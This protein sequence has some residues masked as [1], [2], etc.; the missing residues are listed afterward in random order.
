MRCRAGA[1]G[2]PAVNNANRSSSRA[3]ICSADN[4]RARAAAS[5]IANGIPSTRRHTRATATRLAA[6]SSNV[7]A[8]AQARSTNSRTASNSERSPGGSELGSGVDNGATVNTCS[9]ATHSGS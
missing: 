9:P 6:V 3:R 1:T 7:G 2:D 4:T 8:T 5:S